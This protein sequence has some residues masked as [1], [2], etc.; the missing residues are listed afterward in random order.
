M[1]SG[2]CILIFHRRSLAVLSLSERM[3]RACGC[4]PRPGSTPPVRVAKRACLG[5]RPAAFLP[6]VIICHED[7]CTGKWYARERQSTCGSGDTTDRGYDTGTLAVELGVDASAVGSWTAP[8]L[9]KDLLYSWIDLNRALGFA[10]SLAVRRP[11]DA[12]LVESS[13]CAH[14][15]SEGFEDRLWVVLVVLAERKFGVDAVVIKPL[16]FHGAEH[17]RT[18]IC[19]PLSEFIMA[20]LCISCACLRTATPPTGFHS[21]RRKLSTL[22]S[23]H[24]LPGFPSAE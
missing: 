16:C 2:M 15:P 8:T 9:S 11:H 22:T 18:S 20:H 17:A 7:V 5:Q 23:S 3:P 21:A 14:A 6:Q 10:A 13:G 24:P 1:P 12:S 4:H 19:S